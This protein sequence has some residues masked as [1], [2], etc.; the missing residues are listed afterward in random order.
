MTVYATVG[1]PG[2]G[3]GEAANVAR[4]IGVPVV[5]MGDVIR[6]ECRRRCLPV[7]EDNLGRVASG[8]RE[9]EG[10]DAIAK[11]ALPLVEATHAAYGTVLIDGIRGDVEVDRF[12]ASLGDEF[13]LIAIEAPFELRLERIRDRGRDETADSVADLKRRDRRERG[14]G[15]DRAFE[16]ADKRLDNSGSLEAYQRALIALIK[17]DASA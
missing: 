17:G 3:K 4:R 14:Y 8:L 16:Q 15:M 6:R 11:R 5:T 9:V 1:Y 2:S 12:R 7:T 13:H 10:T